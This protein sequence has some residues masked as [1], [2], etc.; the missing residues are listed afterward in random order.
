MLSF[1]LVYIFQSPPKSLTLGDLMESSTIVHPSLFLAEEL[2]SC[3]APRF[4][5]TI[6]AKDGTGGLVFHFCN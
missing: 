5:R 1:V 3:F 6:L 4:Q 2:A